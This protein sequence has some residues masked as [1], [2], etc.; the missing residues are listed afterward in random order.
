[1]EM[2]ARQEDV[3]ER[4]AVQS[5]VGPVDRS[6]PHHRDRN[7]VVSLP[8]DEQTKCSDRNYEQ[9]YRRVSHSS[10]LGNLIPSLRYC[11]HRLLAHLLSQILTQI[12]LFQIF[13]WVKVIRVHSADRLSSQ[14]IPDYLSGLPVS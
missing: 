14:P 10:F 12:E 13:I 8:E 7:R 6:G 9:D 5:D 4:A 11:Q 3:F 2:L 1:M